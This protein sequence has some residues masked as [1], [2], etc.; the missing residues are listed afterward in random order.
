MKQGN[1]ISSDLVDLDWVGPKIVWMNIYAFTVYQKGTVYSNMSQRTNFTYFAFIVENGKLKVESINFTSVG[2]DTK[3][4]KPDRETASMFMYAIGW[5]LICVSD[6]NANFVFYSFK[7][8][9]QVPQTET[10]QESGYL[11]HTAFG[12]IFGGFF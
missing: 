8:Y 5:N 4:P 12:A 7:N 6:D 10:V 1:G 9:D 11:R 3:V 2:G